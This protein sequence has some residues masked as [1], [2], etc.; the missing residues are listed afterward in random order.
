MLNTSLKRDKTTSPKLWKSVD[1]IS[2]DLMN[3]K[4]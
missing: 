2:R 1:G 3:L 4:N